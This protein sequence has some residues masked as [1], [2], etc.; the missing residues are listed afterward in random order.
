MNFNKVHLERCIEVAGNDRLGRMLYRL[1]RWQPK[2]SIVKYGRRWVAWPRA[3]WM[4][5][6]CLTPNQFRLVLEKL[7]GGP[8]PLVLRRQGIRHGLNVLHLALTD[9]CLLQLVNGPKPLT[10]V[11]GKPL[12]GVGGKPLTLSKNTLRRTHLEE[13]KKIAS[14]SGVAFLGESEDSEKVSPEKQEK[15]TN[16]I[17]FPDQGGSPVATV[18]EIKLAIEAKIAVDAT[19][20]L[21]VYHP[22]SITPLKTI[23]QDATGEYP[24]G[25]VCGMLKTLIKKVD[26]VPAPELLKYAVAHWGDIVYE[27]EASYSAFKCPDKPKLSWLLTH[28]HVAV[29]C[30]ARHDKKA[31][32]SIASL[33]DPNSMAAKKL[34]HLKMLGVKVAS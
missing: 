23:W 14:A 33:A 12:A 4:K 25:P 20:P 2:T 11:S 28:A 7:T 18:A 26:P 22:D 3:T 30:K 10:G 21:K 19:K 17:P 13:H 6:L 1:V 5:E 27:A 29:I 31:A 8:D 15:Q 32:Q 34:A 16:V 24:T 9:S